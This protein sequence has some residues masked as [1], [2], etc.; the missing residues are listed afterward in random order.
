MLLKKSRMYHIRVPIAVIA[1]LLF[2]P[3]LSAFGQETWTLE[4]AV[5][6]ALE[7]SPEIS[8]AKAAVRERQGLLRQA[9]AWPNPEI[10][11]SLD[12]RMG[13][14]D[15]RG[16]T[17]LTELAVTQPL[18]LSGR[19]DRQ[20]QVADAN[21]KLAEAEYQYRALQVEFQAA[22][23]FHA[24]QLA[25]E[26]L[27][28][29]K[30]GLTAA[31]R[32]QTVG[33]LR[34]RA[35]DLSQLERLR[36]DMIR[37]AAWQAVA[38]AEG[39]YNEALANFRTYTGVTEK[40]QPTPLTPVSPPAP[41]QTLQDGLEHHPELT[42]AGYRLAAARATTDLVRS[43][44]Y[45]DLSLSLFTGRDFVGNQRQNIAG[46]SVAVPL[47]LWDRKSGQLTASR[48]QAENAEFEMQALRRNLENRLRQSHLHLG[49][50][51][52]QA[53]GYRTR[54]LTPAKEVFD[55]AGQGYAAGEVDILALIDANDTYF[56]VQSRYLSLLQA[57]WL[58]ASTLSLASG[59]SLLSPE[60]PTAQG[61][62]P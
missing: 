46:A 42:A 36:L 1:C 20:R 15:G 7:V 13:K 28:L 58:E 3:V 48:A 38:T 45:P 60:R 17:D 5:Q 44:R 30:Q 49:H 55:K 24:L 51:I 39:Q 27:A 12:N 14:E 57:A 8:A 10:S 47:P 9:G 41:L 53:E 34:E 18:P 62:Q 2:S 35:G 59:I 56:A 50:L 23:A 4:R 26:T 43:E 22:G 21:L 25:R 33:R 37:E 11:V 40:V 19:L 29:A 16:G 61:T 54:M 52:Q 31:H 32:F 6:R